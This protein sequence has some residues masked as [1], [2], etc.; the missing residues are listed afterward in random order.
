MSAAAPLLLSAAVKACGGRTGAV[1]RKAS[2]FISPCPRVSKSKIRAESNCEASIT[3]PK[4]TPISEPTA[5]SRNAGDAAVAKGNIR[6]RR[7]LGLNKRKNNGKNADRRKKK[8]Q[9]ALFF[10]HYPH[11][12]FIKINMPAE[13]AISTSED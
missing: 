13:R 3:A 5:E 11:T 2:A 6:A 7:A 10:C 1:S 4:R 9:S 8:L 12:P